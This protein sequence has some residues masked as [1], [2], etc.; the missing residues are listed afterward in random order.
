MSQ[1]TEPISP[2]PCA[3]S[4]ITSL[5][6]LRRL[7]A[8]LLNSPAVA[9]DTESDSLYSYHE[10]ICLVQFSLPD[11]DFIIDPL[12]IG[13]LDPL[14][15]VFASPSVEK[16]FHGADYDIISLKRGYGFRF[17]SIFD[18]M[19]ASRILGY[20]SYGLSSLLSQHL[21]IT[22]DKRMQRSD[23]GQ[24]PLTSAQL[25]YA[26]H[27][28]RHLLRLH[29]L[30]RDE[31]RRAG[32]EEEAQEIF[33]DL[34]FLEPRPKAFDPDGF[35]HL[36]GVRELDAPGL[37]VVRALWLWR[38]QQARSADRPVFK[39]VGDRAL[40]ALARV[41]PTSVDAL[42]RSALLSRFQVERY[43]EAIVA[44]V[45]EALASREPVRRPT[46]RREG[47]PLDATT[48]TVHEALRVW[49]KERAAQRG[50]E[51]DIVAPNDLL[52]TLAS[53]RPR[54][55]ADLETIPGLGPWRRRTYGAD[56]LATI[57]RALGP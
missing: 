10:K 49:R 35:W 46:R 21:G 39:I 28:T 25:A 37:R 1:S 14:A 26:C 38:D 45:A 18:T 13:S 16:I 40:L 30:L 51:P 52:L 23:W 9:V 42:R 44:T 15:E 22:L 12:S 20:R 3:P 41:R 7:S 4:L 19:V 54:N 47:P 27:D 6:A 57:A 2:L 43:G 17:A 55:L 11:S 56:I 5:S 8:R 32:C 29:A 24:R 33:A 48:I 36:A 34:A 31:L 50:T 53:L